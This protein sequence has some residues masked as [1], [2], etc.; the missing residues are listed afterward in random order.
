MNHLLGCFV[1]AVSLLG[2][3]VARKAILLGFYALL[4]GLLY[5]EEMDRGAIGSASD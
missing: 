5:F 2:D 3:I 1:L 4:D